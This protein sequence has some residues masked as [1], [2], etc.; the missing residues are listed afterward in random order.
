M[1][2]SVLQKFSLTREVLDLNLDLRLKRHEAVKLS[3][4]VFITSVN[5][6]DQL[7]RVFFTSWKYNVENMQRTFFKNKLN[8]SDLK[9]PL[10]IY[11]C[12]MFLLK[13]RP[14]KGLVEK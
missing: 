7:Q 10:Y 11:D 5:K 4:A 1:E 13:A 3:T 8:I 9:F 12:L 6:N 14:K 2:N